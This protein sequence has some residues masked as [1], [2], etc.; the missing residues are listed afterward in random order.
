MMTKEHNNYF[1]LA[2]YHITEYCTI[3]L[4]VLVTGIVQCDL[5]SIILCEGYPG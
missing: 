1:A 5:K 4:A 2:R 3:V